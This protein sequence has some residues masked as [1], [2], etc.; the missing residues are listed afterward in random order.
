[1]LY[2]R[3]LHLIRCMWYWT[4]HDRLDIQG[5][6]WY[7]CWARSQLTKLHGLERTPSPPLEQLPTDGVS[8]VAPL[9]E[10]LL[11]AVMDLQALHSRVSSLNCN[12]SMDF[13]ASHTCAL[14]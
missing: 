5:W 3:V 12:V 11:H 8:A 13:A 2:L 9:V 4:V 6:G 10:L 7:D 1:M 14:C